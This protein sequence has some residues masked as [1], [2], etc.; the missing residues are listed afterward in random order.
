MYLQEKLQ[1]YEQQ[2]AEYLVVEFHS[3]DKNRINAIIPQKIKN[4]TFTP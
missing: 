1:V 3:L 4:N 2:L